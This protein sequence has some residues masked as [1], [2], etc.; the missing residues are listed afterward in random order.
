MLYLACRQIIVSNCWS[1]ANR[2]CM[3]CE[4][5]M[6]LS[7]KKSSSNLRIKSVHNDNTHYNY[8]RVP[9]NTEDGIWYLNK[10]QHAEGNYSQ[11]ET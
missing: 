10:A 9:L 2:F 11:I 4:T 3:V 8:K 7:E 5:T 6:V 1:S